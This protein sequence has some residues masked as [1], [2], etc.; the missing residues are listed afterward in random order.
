MSSYSIHMMKSQGCFTQIVVV[1]YSLVSDVT[2]VLKMQDENAGQDES[3][4]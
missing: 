4:D 2:G 1:Q 3:Q